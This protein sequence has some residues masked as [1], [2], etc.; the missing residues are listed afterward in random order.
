MTICGWW[1]GA[2]HPGAPYWPWSPGPCPG[3]GPF[4]AGTLNV[5]YKRG[6]VTFLEC[7]AM[8]LAVLGISEPQL[9]WKEPKNA[10]IFQ[11]QSLQPFRNPQC[12]Q[13]VPSSVLSEHA[14]LASAYHSYT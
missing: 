1:E 11:G 4:L 2:P 12:L 9:P 6:S 7:A 8:C 5:G 14:G 13:L 10:S 3:G